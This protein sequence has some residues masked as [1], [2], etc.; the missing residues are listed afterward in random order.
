MRVVKIGHSTGRT[1]CATDALRTEL[2]QL[3]AE[4]DRVKAE[5]DRVRWRI[6]A[7]T[8]HEPDMTA[9]VFKRVEAFLRQ[10]AGTDFTPRQ[11]MAAVGGNEDA[12]R[13][14]LTYLVVDGWLIK[15]AHGHYVINPIT[16]APDWE[17][18]VR[19]R[20]W[21]DPGDP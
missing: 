6:N 10:W 19:Q 12:V 9:P 18:H 11:L 15:T 7:I 1:E 13:K 5:A 14:A 17:S 20:G 16:P 4:A 8:E 21:K 2:A 3:E